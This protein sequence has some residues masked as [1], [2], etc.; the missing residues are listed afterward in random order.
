[1]KKYLKEIVILFIQLLLFYIFPIFM[2]LYEPIGMVM[3]MLMVTF[4]LGMIIGII[5]NN[6]IKYFY[7]IIIAILFLPSVFIFYNESALIH[8]LWYLVISTVGLF[9]GSIINLIIGKIKV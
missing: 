1:M 2:F 8:S 4:I 7:P 3:I 6:K 9:I 5:S